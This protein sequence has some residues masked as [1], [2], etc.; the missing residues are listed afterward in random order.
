M[1]LRRDECFKEVPGTPRRKAQ[2]FR[3][4]VRQRTLV[5]AW[6]PAHPPCDA[7]VTASKHRPTEQRS[8]KIQ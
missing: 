2:A 3:L 8:T 5:G 7:P 1:I 4:R 6:R